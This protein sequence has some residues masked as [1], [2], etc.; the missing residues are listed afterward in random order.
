MLLVLWV[1][2]Y[3]GFVDTEVQ[4]QEHREETMS[5]MTGLGLARE[6]LGDGSF[7]SVKM[8]HI[9]V[10][11]VVVMCRTASMN[12]ERGEVNSADE[13]KFLPDGADSKL[14]CM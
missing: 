8:V 1:T 14:G 9:V 5:T 10:L 13:I 12:S 6:I 2:M 3:R 7:E 4:V 11:T